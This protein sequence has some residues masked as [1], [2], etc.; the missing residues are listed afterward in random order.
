MISCHSKSPDKG[1]LYLNED[2]INKC[3]ILSAAKNPEDSDLK[4]FFWILHFVQNDC[5]N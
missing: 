5:L 4:N 1:R 2:D 3:V